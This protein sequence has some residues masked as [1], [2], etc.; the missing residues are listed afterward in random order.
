V[1]TIVLGILVLAVFFNLPFVKK[2]LDLLMRRS[3]EGAGIVRAV[4]YELLLKVRDGFSISDLE[5]EP[6]HPLAGKTLGETRPNDRGIVVLGIYRKGGGFE[7]V[8][9]KNSVLEAG[10][11]IMFYGNREAVGWL[12]EG[13][14]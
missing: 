13:N 2:P 7:G 12:V 10:D 6:G 8:P 5:I 4:D 1:G 11:T 3:L 9:G 14:A